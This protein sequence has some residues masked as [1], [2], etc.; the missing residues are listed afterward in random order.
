MPA[1]NSVQQQVHLSWDSWPNI[2]FPDIYSFLIERTSEFTRESLKAYKSLE[3]YNQYCNGWVGNVNVY[4]PMSNCTYIATAPVRHS[5]SISA[6]PLRPWVAIEKNGSVL[7]GHCTCMAGLGEACS[8]IAALLFTLDGNTSYKLKASCTSL[9][10]SWLP[11]SLQNVPYSEISEINFMTPA[12]QKQLLTSKPLSTTH[13]STI[14]SAGPST[15]NVSSQQSCRMFQPP[16]EG[17]IKAFYMALA[18]DHSH[19]PAILSV[20]PEHCDRYVPLNARPDV[21][22]TP[23]NALFDES[24]VGLSYDN[25]VAKCSTLPLKLSL[26]Q[27]VSVEKATRDQAKSRIWHQQRAGRITASRVKAAACTNIDK[28][29]KSLIK[30]ICYPNSVTFQSAAC[31]Y[32]C[33]H[34]DVARKNYKR[35]MSLKHTDV[36]I[37]QCGFFISNEHPFL[38]ASPDGVMSCSCCSG[39]TVVEIK[40][41]FCCR[42]KSFDEKAVEGSFCLEQSPDGTLTLKHNHQYYY[43]I[44]LQMYCCNAAVGDFVVWRKGE[45]LIERIEYDAMFMESVIHKTAAFFYKLVLPELVGKVLTRDKVA[46]I[47]GKSSETAISNDQQFLECWCYCKRPESFDD[48]VGCD[49]PNCEIGWYHLS[50]LGITADDLPDSWI[51]PQCSVNASE[52]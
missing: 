12:K 37:R 6:T 4:Q 1:E 9:P 52:L 26:T 42:D 48:M 46:E 47:T 29:S 7:C 21:L 23:L 40:C 33:Q 41:P 3:G 25:L 5:Q 36:Q 50:C 39:L 19:K 30:A 31:A 8:H 15:S 51:C 27:V 14:Q 24:C 17:E 35:N 20:V 32:G 13:D 2:G 49:N 43:Q 44:Q 34:E 10:C 11:P 18:N 28:P 22:P 38:G 45:I 16:T